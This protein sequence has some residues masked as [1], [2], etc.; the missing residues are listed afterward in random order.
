VPEKERAEDDERMRHVWNASLQGAQQLC[1]D[2]VS[3]VRRV[4]QRTLILSATAGGVTGLINYRAAA[5]TA[6]DDCMA[7]K[8]C[9]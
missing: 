1:A 8:L 3:D 6:C 4:R 5:W 2:S 7:C 9:L